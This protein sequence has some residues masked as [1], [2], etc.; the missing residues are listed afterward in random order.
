[1]ALLKYKVIY[2]DGTEIEVIGTPYAQV[3]TEERYGGINEETKLRAT[4][5][6]AWASLNKAG[7][8]PDSFETWLDKIADIEELTGQSGHPTTGGI[9]SPDESSPSAP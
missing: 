1:M 5:H 8:E 4:Y 3:R 2:L 7:K 9:P 6:L